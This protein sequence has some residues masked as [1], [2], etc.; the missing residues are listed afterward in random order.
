VVIYYPTSSADA[1]G[2]TSLT[3]AVRTAGVQGILNS[4]SSS[5]KEM[6]AQ[7]GLTVSHTFV[8]A[9]ETT[10]QRGDKLVYDSR[11]LM[12]VGINVNEAMG[13]IQT[14]SKLTLNEVI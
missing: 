1:G 7:M 6:Y 4:A 3:Y 8:H 2:G 9:G 10:A 5:E 14:H 13:G 11:S 12:I